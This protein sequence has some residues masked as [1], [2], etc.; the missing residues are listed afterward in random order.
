MSVYNPPVSG[1]YNYDHVEVEIKSISD[2]TFSQLIFNHP[3]QNTVR[4][5]AKCGEDSAGR[6]AA[7]F[8][9]SET[10]AETMFW[11]GSSTDVIGTIHTNNNLYVGGQGNFVDGLVTYVSEHF[12]PVDKITYDHPTR[13]NNPS[14]SGV[15][16]YPGD[17]DMNNYVPGGS[18]ALEAGDDHHGCECD[19]FLN[20]EWYDDVNKVLDPGLYYTT[21][22][23]DLSD[24][25]KIG[26]DGMGKVTFISRST[27]SLT[28]S[29][30]NLNHYMDGLLA[31]TDMEYSDPGDKCVKFVIKMEGSDSIWN[32]IINAP[33]GMI[34]MAGSTNNSTLNGSLLGN[35]V[36]LNGSNLNIIY[37]ATL[38][39]DVTTLS[40]I[41]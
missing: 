21:E 8:A 30:V 1:S 35:T 13:P 25:L 3:L 12:D 23:I 26:A 31:F 16:D 17:F 39:P 19:I 2:G 10:C 34:E 6:G 4:A 20:P 27:I 28:A 11:P 41:E 29:S 33:N 7:I 9:D 32:G 40:L 38:F 14:K 24:T 37:D 5:I 18:K 15:K 36:K 22:D